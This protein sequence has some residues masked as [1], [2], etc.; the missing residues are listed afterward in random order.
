[1]AKPSISRRKSAV[2]AFVALTLLA[3]IAVTSYEWPAWRAAS[4]TR[5]ELAAG[6]YA[7]AQASAERWVRLRPR[8]AEAHF[9]RA[10]AALALGRRNDLVQGMLQARA[11]GYP[12]DRLAVL[13]A[14]VDAHA[15]R[16]VLARPILIRAFNEAAEPDLMV[17]EALS[18]VLMELY[19]WPHAGAILKRWGEHAPN[20]PR[21]LLWHAAVNRRRDSDPEV[22]AADFR[23]ALRR[24]PTLAE[25]RLGLAE[26]LAR[27]GKYREAGSEFEA[28]LARVPDD[29]AG[30]LGAGRVALELGDLDLALRR[31]DRAL[32]LDPDNAEAHIE[33]ARFSRSRGDDADALAHLDR[34]IALRPYD[35]APRYNRRLALIR[36]GRTDEARK[37]Q[38]AIDLLKADL[39]RMNDLQDRLNKSPN[40]ANLQSKLALWML[41]HGY[42]QEG[43]KWAGKILTDHPGHRETCQLLARYYEQ[44]G[45]LGLA[46]YY[47]SQMA[48][49]MSR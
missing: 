39:D 38:E 22:I 21:P 25:A 18:R 31:F 41:T 1:M 42:D 7:E 45:N 13:Q 17:D 36:L 49:P 30:Q 10:K 34:A 6:R 11:L 28:Y 24:D 8:S 2:V 35:P 15:G 27:T 44:K 26:E 9:L 19:D 3:A 16:F 20:D 48:R 47:Q 37:E 46:V 29:P 14:L 43:L 32:A 5:R 33:K 40:D 12:E 4:E 23:E